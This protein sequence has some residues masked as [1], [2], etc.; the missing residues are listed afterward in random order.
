MLDYL[1]RLHFHNGM[2]VDFVL[3]ERH[4]DI[5]MLDDHVTLST[6]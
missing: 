3:L 6:S 4:Y 1:F 2:D 5:A